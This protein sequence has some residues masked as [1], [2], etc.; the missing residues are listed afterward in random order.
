MRDDVV[1]RLLQIN[2]EFYQTF[3][4]AFAETRRRLQPGVRRILTVIPPQ[5]AVLDLGCGG[6]LVAQELARAGFRG[7]YVGVDWSLA[8]LKEARRSRLP[9]W[10]LLEAVDLARPGWSSQLSGPFDVLLAFA[11][12]HHLPGQEQRAT[13]VCEAVRVMADSGRMVVSVW[14]F[15]ASARLRRRVV[16]W[17]EIGLQAED[18][19]SGDYLLDWRRGGRGLRYVHHFTSEELAVL[20]GRAGMVVEQQFLSDGEAGRLGLYQVW[21]RAAVHESSRVAGDLGDCLASHPV[22]E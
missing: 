18:L 17:E 15:L 16:S 12:L 20:A 14:N 7:R 3:G 10:A 2:R 4:P 13:F 5:A 9:S 1:N 21:M 11:L 6:G 22:V 8:L 19:E